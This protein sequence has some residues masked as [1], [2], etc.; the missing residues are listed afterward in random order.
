MRGMSAQP[1]AVPANAAH[2]YHCGLPVPDGARFALVLGGE[3]R[4]LCCAGC[5][6]VARAIVG[7]GLE[8]YYRKRDRFP[9]SPREALPEVVRD[10]A[11]FDRPEVQGGF[12]S[13]S[14]EHEREAALILEGITC[15]ACVWLNETHLSRLPGVSAVHIN[16][17]TRRARV[18]W[19]ARATS[20]SKILR[21]VRAIGYRAYP[22]DAQALEESRRRESRSMLLRLAVAGLGMMQVMMYA[23]PGYLAAEGEIGADIAALMRWASFALTLPVVL[24]SA[25][26]FFS[27]ALR[28]LR[29]GRP[30]MDVPVA[31]GVAG[32]FL[33]SAAAT[34]TGKGE[35]Y[36]ESVAMFVF[37]LLGGRYLEMRARHKAADYLE[38]LSRALPATANRLV[39]FPLCLNTE[40]VSAAA[41]SVGDYVLVHPGETFPVDGLLE[42]GDTEADESLLTGESTAVEKSEGA[43]VIGGSVNR[44]NPA[45]VRVERV[46]EHTALSSLVRLMERAAHERP[47]LQEITDRVAGRFVTFVLAAAAAAAL[48]W[49]AID[50]ARALPIAVAVLVVTCPCAL[51]LATPMVLAVAAAT[52]ARNGLIVTRGHA[53]E[54]LARATHFVFDKTGTLTAGRPGV[55]R[56]Q[57]FGATTRKEALGLAAALERGS[58]HPLG[59]AIVEA[60]GWSST[61]ATRLRSLAG[62]GMQGE[63]EGRRL[64]IGRKAFALEAAPQAIAPAAEGPASATEIWLAGESGPIAVFALADAV[65]A[66]ARAAVGEL[67][68]RGKEVVLLSGDREDAVRTVAAETGIAEFRAG[69]TPE[70]KQAFVKTLQSR[71]AVVA[72]VGDG[73]NDAPVLAQAQVSVA[74][75]SGTALAQAAADMVLISHRLESLVRGVRLCVRALRVVRQNLY[76]AFAYNVIALPLACA[77]YVTPWLAAVGMSASSLAVVLNA[78]RVRGKGASG[79]WRTGTT[80]TGDG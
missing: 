61:P 77:G 70:Q 17:A 14:G 60:A 2:C 41:L 64:R 42:Q 56:V 79:E 31:L 71:G 37:F 32:A 27:G 50:P 63:V 58:E 28:D 62:Q 66:D 73:V 7:A 45:V 48:V 12:V 26:P 9:D 6:A 4:A 16:Y 52:L 20:L 3:S 39:N 68:E 19:D 69:L 74:M 55:V 72:M 5:E 38:F 78:L 49:L 46:G 44:G 76:W 43:A 67:R 80:V 30:G 13:V 47:R 40:S 35:V 57:T 36:F 54:T 59:R 25:L 65:R 51:S 11:V 10:L 22:Y 18:R 29:A 34:F 24:Y 15:P 1:A 75:A 33:A 21:A 53:I 23:V 8:S